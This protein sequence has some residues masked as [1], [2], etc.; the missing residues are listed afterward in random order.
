M[1]YAFHPEAAAEHLGY[2]A[3][4]ESRRKGLGARYLTGFEAVMARVSRDPRRFRIECEPGLR[5]SRVRGFPLSVIYREVENR[6][7][8]QA[9]AHQR[10]RPDNGKAGAP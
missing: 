3:L 8:V 1:K 10:R 4:Y 2:V 9:V 6:V 7:Q 5:R